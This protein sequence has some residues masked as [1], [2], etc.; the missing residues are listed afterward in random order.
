MALTPFLNSDD[1]EAAIVDFEAWERAV[2]TLEN[3]IR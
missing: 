1:P 3:T 2:R